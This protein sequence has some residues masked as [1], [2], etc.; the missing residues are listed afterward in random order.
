LF[1]GERER[2]VVGPNGA[3]IAGMHPE[4]E[5]VEAGGLMSYGIDFPAQWR[6]AASYVDRILRGA[7]PGDLPIEQPV[8]FELVVSAR[9]GR[10]LG[11][12]LPPSF[13][14]RADEVLE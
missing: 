14:A 7:Q 6:R 8:R 3:G 13:L 2:I 4:R 10:A 12:R 1:Y 5:F 11:V 9:T